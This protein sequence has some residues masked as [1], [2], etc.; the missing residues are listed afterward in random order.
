MGKN[1]GLGAD[2]SEE[3][4]TGSVEEQVEEKE[5]TDWEELPQEHR[6]MISALIEKWQY[7]RGALPAEEEKLTRIFTTTDVINGLEITLDLSLPDTQDVWKEYVSQT[8]DKSGAQIELNSAKFEIYNEGDTKK[9]RIE[10]QLN[11]GAEQTTNLLKRAGRDLLKGISYNPDATK[12]KLIVRLYRFEKAGDQKADD[13][14]T[15]DP[16]YIKFV[17]T[18]SYAEDASWVTIS[19]KT[20]E[21]AA[22]ISNSL[23]PEE[24]AALLRINWQGMAERM[25]TRA[26]IATMSDSFLSTEPEAARPKDDRDSTLVKLAKFT[27]QVAG[28][29]PYFGDEQKGAVLER[30]KLRRYG[31]IWGEF[32]KPAE[33][34]S[35]ESI[36]QLNR[37]IEVITEKEELLWSCRGRM[38]Q[39]PSG[40]SRYTFSIPPQAT[41]SQP[42]ALTFDFDES[43]RSIKTDI[44]IGWLKVI[45]NSQ[46]DFEMLTED[47]DGDTPQSVR[48]TYPETEHQQRSYNEMAAMVTI[49]LLDIDTIK[50]Y[51]GVQ[52][53]RDPIATGTALTHADDPTITPGKPSLSKIKFGE[54]DK[55]EGDIDHTD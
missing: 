40:P 36:L 45:Q 16:I 31:V 48:I 38:K 15:D 17:P 44:K 32:A 51:V 35:E 20:M 21:N 52:L 9:T 19:D 1:E 49:N 54:E 43:T 47:Q 29:N 6:N 46:R 42:I 28:Y 3:V 34:I 4:E 7:L 41:K 12:S 39:D 2:H 55:H 10:F 50:T 30:R 24:I 53:L 22:E 18:F 14:N 11:I 33:K 23:E 25:I 27:N 26:T 13:Q 37:L 8:A 5:P